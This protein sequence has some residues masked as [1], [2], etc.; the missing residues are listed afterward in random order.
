MMRPG[1]METRYSD[2][3]FT[4]L[5][6]AIVLIA[7]IVVAA[8]FSY[9]VL[10]AAVR[11]GVQQADPHLEVVGSLLG[12][13]PMPSA[14]LRYINVSVA[15]T[16]GSSALDLTRMVVSYNDGTSRNANV[17]NAT[18]GIDDCTT[19]AILSADHGLA[20]QRW[21]VSQKINEVGSP[22]NL[23][24]PHEIWI[25]SVG[26]PETATANQKIA[27]NFIP[28]GGAYLPVTATVP[29]AITIVQPLS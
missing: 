10:N 24:E 17:L 8:V 22:N 6:A 2:D 29:G 19:D 9:V 11:P 16:A 15:L 12:I 23:L 27:I 21:C 1:A 5:E 26:M 20:G 3:A 14:Q 4:G 18:A 28:A 7:F 25:I 13:S